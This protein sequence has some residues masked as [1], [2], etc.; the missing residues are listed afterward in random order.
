[1]TFEPK[2][3]RISASLSRCCNDTARREKKALEVVLA[4][5]V[6]RACLSSGCLRASS[7]KALSRSSPSSL[8][9]FA[10]CFLR[11][12]RSFLESPPGVPG[13]GVCGVA[14]SATGV[15]AAEVVVGFFFFFFY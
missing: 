6:G 13:S 9:A 10:F 7:A 12:L 8:A 14:T 11:A 3:R 15:A 2:N 4:V 1:M 5:L